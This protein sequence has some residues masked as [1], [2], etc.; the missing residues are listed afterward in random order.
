MVKSKQSFEQFSIA[1]YLVKWLFFGTVMALA[2]GSLV[3]LFLYLLDLVTKLRWNNPWLVYLLPISG[4]AIYWLYA[5]WGKKTEA[6]NNLIIDEIHQPDG[7]IP[8]RIA[9][10]VLLSTLITHLFGGSAGREG[11]AV[12][13]GA[14]IAGLFG[15][16]MR[17]NK[18]DV[19]ILLMAGI[20]AG[21]SAVFGTPVSGTVFAM[22]VIAIGTVK[23]DAL[24]PCLIASM[25]AHFTC[26]AWGIQ[27]IQ[28][29][30]PFNQSSMVNW[31]PMDILLL[32]K[33]IVSGI[34]F[35]LIA[36]AFANAQTAIKNLANKYIPY[37][38]LIP[39]IGG[40]CIIGLTFLLNTNDYLGLGVVAQNTD[41]VS[42]L[43]AF[44]ANGVTHW[45]WLWKFL[46]TIITLGF[47]FKG[48]EVTPLFF[49]GAA[50][51]NTIAWT[52]GA[53]VE[54]FAA[55]GFIA[56]FAGATNTPL[57]C[58]I[59]GVEL[60]GGEHILYYAVACF[61]A[62]SFSGHT[63][64]YHTQRTSISKTHFKKHLE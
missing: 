38:W 51:G 63:G 19:Q 35:G 21:F 36:F 26:I 15:K 1:N 17:L 4:I 12:Q 14:G 6:G 5:F 29:L 53:P 32:S 23:Y 64:I 34:L 61:L 3:A 44:H 8:A 62:Y 10:L 59:M 57:A 16:W 27:H 18:T 7:G 25:I 55:L 60:F 45:S 13:M 39:A 20:A 28:Y 46:F 42:I 54:L 56:V 33:I 9:P 48:G 37:Q 41:G 43:A 58:T 52:L 2:V 40:L 50:L 24:V 30:L 31:L 22:E 47:G 49:I 11:T